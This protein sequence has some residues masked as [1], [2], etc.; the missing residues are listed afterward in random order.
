MHLQRSWLGQSPVQVGQFRRLFQ[1]AHVV[2][3]TESF[4]GAS[5]YDDGSS[6]EEPLD[7]VEEKSITTRP[8]SRPLKKTRFEEGDNEYHDDDALSFEERAELW[9]TVLE[10]QV[11][12]DRARAFVK[13]IIKIEKGQD[14]SLSYCG[15]FFR[16]YD[17]CCNLEPTATCSSADNV[18]TADDSHKLATWMVIA[19]DRWG[20][21]RL[22]IRK[23]HGDRSMRRKRNVRVV[24]EM[25][26]VLESVDVEVKANYIRKA[27][28]HITRPSVLFAQLIAQAQATAL[29]GD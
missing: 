19:S 29:S 16:I 2:K 4:R 8:W 21:E 9:H 20:L 12:K 17:Q 18:L 28:E 10:I 5:A 7:L 3:A 13:D 6:P 25:Q 14:Q 26:S 11:F 15:V 1:G 27:G 22:S 24:L 23:I